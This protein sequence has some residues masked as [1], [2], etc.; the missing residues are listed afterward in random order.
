MGS[1]QSDKPEHSLEGFVAPWRMKDLTNY[2][3]KRGDIRVAA[4]D[5][6][7]LLLHVEYGTQARG[8]QL[9]SKEVTVGIL[10]VRWLPDQ[11]KEKETFHIAPFAT[12]GCFRCLLEAK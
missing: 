2:H 7:G 12:Q 10:P 1:P 6:E 11:T 9:G 5:P 3:C 8:P 4:D